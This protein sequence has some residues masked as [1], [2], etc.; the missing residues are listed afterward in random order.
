MPNDI[1]PALCVHF[2]TNAVKG[3]FIVRA[4]LDL[5][6][7]LQIVYVCIYVSMCDPMS[8]FLSYCVAR[9]LSNFTIRGCISVLCSSTLVVWNVL[10]LLVTHTSRFD[11]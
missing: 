11:E 10:V 2:D 4:L 7:Q 1:E 5:A 6:L 9:I 8:L 3:V